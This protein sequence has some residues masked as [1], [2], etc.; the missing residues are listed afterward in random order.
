MIYSI[1]NITYI[2]DNFVTQSFSHTGTSSSVRG[3]GAIALGSQILSLLESLQIT[4]FWMMMRTRTSKG[5]QMDL[6][7]SKSEILPT[8][9]SG[10]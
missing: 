10:W 8:T 2:D 5:V 9:G 3:S 6:W 4:T 7:R 1:Q